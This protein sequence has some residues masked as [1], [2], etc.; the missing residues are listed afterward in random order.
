MPRL[1]DVGVA[2]TR[3]EDGTGPLTRLLER[4]CGRVVHWPCVSF[5]PP[6]DT[7]P[8]RLALADLEAFDWIAV[9]SPR[10]ADVLV[11]DAAQAPARTRIA[12]AGPAT[13][14]RLEEA[15]WTVHVVPDSYGGA[16]LVEALAASGEARGARILFPCS[17]RAL[18]ATTDGLTR[19]GATVERVVAYRTLPGSPDAAE[20][21]ADVAAGGVQVVTFASPS[22]VTGLCRALT[23]DEA[24][25]VL[26]S[27]PCAAIGD[28]TAAAL[29]E[30]GYPPAAVAQP[31]TLAGLVDAT[32]LAAGRTAATKPEAT[33]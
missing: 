20:I 7:G 13:A 2:V 30:A 17:D 19:L 16:P 23:P 10:A 32:V 9:T 26:G 28:T 24:A 18:P 6:E 33:T 15:G 5:G 11:R 29:R 31:S 1:A 27:V 21:M 25:G 22:A 4:E 14:G 3:A 8:L 12:A